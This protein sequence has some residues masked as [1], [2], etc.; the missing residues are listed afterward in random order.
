MI[1]LKRFFFVIRAVQ[2]WKKNLFLRFS[3]AGSYIL[4]VPNF[5]RKRVW[6]LF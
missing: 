4:K 1:F 2:K 6:I 5:I 3:P